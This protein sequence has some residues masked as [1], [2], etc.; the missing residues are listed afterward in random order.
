LRL[1]PWRLPDAPDL[2]GDP[3]DCEKAAMLDGASIPVLIRHVLVPLAR[4]G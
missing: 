1:G 3:R 4:P 2:S